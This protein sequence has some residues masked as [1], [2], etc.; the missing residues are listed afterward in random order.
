MASM[1]LLELKASD[2]PMSKPREIFDILSITVE[3][4]SAF[5][6]FVVFFCSLFYF[7][8]GAAAVVVTIYNMIVFAVLAPIIGAASGLMLVIWN[9]FKI[10]KR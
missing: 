3:T 4:V 8:N 1:L 6:V 10:F 2:E 9:L 5:L 7:Q